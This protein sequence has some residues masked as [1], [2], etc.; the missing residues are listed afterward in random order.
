MTRLALL[1][2]T[3][4]A[5]LSASTAVAGWYVDASVGAGRADQTWYVRASDLEADLEFEA[6]TVWRY[7]L[8]VGVLHSSR[9]EFGAELAWSQRGGA[10]VYN[11]SVLRPGKKRTL[12]FKRSY[13]DISIPVRRSW[14]VGAASVG[15]GISPRASRYL[16]EDKAFSGT[17]RPEDWV[18]GIDPDLRLA[19]SLGYVW[20]R[21][22]WDLG[23]SYRVKQSKM[24]DRVGF[25]GIGLRLR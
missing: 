10:V 24:E 4:V 13:L 23:P 14:R 5:S 1:Y 8:G 16:E 19:Y 3:A 22:C 17:F 21:Y 20:A 25:I 15:V 6:I 12:E 18:F 11:Q 7:S 9:F 2:L